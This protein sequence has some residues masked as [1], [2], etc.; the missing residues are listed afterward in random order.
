MKMIL[1]LILF[2]NVGYAQFRILGKTNIP[3]GEKI[4]LYSN[5]INNDS[6]IDSVIIKNNAFEFSRRIQEPNFYSIYSSF[7]KGN[8][9]FIWDGTINI[10]IDSFI[11][12]G[13]HARSKLTEEWVNYKKK[14]TDV[15]DDSLRKLSIQYSKTPVTDSFAINENIQKQKKI[16][17]V[18]RSDAE[19]Y[20]NLN[21]SSFISLYLYAWLFEQIDLAKAES[22]LIK[23]KNQQHSY[24]D[25]FFKKIE[26]NK[27][28]SVGAIIKPFSVN[29]STNNMF[30]FRIPNSNKIL[31]D[32]WG[33]WCGPCIRMIPQLKLF[34]GSIKDLNVTVLSIAVENDTNG[35]RNSEKIIKTNEMDW[36]HAIGLRSTYQDLLKQ[37][38]ITVFPTEILINNDGRILYRKNGAVSDFNEIETLINKKIKD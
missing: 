13:S 29:T 4:F 25:Y 15:L 9:Q 18:Y 20:I 27:P 22:L 33:S 3:N 23:L 12:K 35:L 8:F 19:H 24:V 11:F 37:F 21:P 16:Y 5:D 31:L 6:L 26:K 7:K 30:E 38:N 2:V 34:Y 32:F 28:S 36:I 14:F 17:E 1:I 10:F